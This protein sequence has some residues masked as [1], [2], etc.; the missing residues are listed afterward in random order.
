MHLKIGI[1]FAVVAFLNGFSFCAIGGTE[2]QRDLTLY[3]K[4]DPYTLERPRG[5]PEQMRKVEGIR[6]FLWKH[7]REHRQGFLE[8]TSYGLEGQKTNTRYFVEASPA[9]R[10]YVAVELEM[11]VITAKGTRAHPRY[12]YVA[13]VVERVEL[14]EG[15]M[16]TAER[17]PIPSDET[18]ASDSYQLLL[19]DESGK[20]LTGM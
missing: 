10:W 9:G 19:K 7:W 2:K 18:R 6:E 13:T 17:T 8:V 11:E 16:I 15:D 20:V 3:E 12:T 14:P 1:Y 4:A 5:E